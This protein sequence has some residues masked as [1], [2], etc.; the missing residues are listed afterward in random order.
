MRRSDHPLALPLP[1]AVLVSIVPL[2]VAGAPRICYAADVTKAQCV[3]ANSSAQSLRRSGRFSAA[4]EQLLLCGD[5]KCP[6][7]V[8]VDC[9]RRLDELEQTQPTIVFEVKDASGGDISAVNVTLDGHPFA[10]KL[11]GTALKVDPGS[12]AFTFSAAGQTPVTKNLVVVEGEKGRRE[13]IVI[14]SPEATPPGGEPTKAG[15]Q[16]AETTAAPANGPQPGAL[17]TGASSS[18]GST[19]RTLGLVAGGA[20]VVG[21]AVGSVFGLLASSS[22]N[23]QKSDCASLTQCKNYGQAVSDHDRTET[24]GTVSTVAFIAGGVLLAGG[25]VLFF[26]A[27]HVVVSPAVGYGTAGA[28]VSGRF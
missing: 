24:D 3:D 7:V 4:R 23:A 26:T 6:D 19:Q 17:S 9:A 28:T 18:D 12:H 22:F 1:L 5:S 13:R 14:G 20:G 21:I 16:S 8:R 11:D 10:D 27:P 15:Q 2:A 25:A